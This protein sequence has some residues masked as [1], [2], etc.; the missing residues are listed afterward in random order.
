METQRKESL[1]D[2]VTRPDRDYEMMLVL[3]P[4]MPEE[5]TQA[6]IDKIRGYITDVNA[7]IT[8][9]LTDSP[10]GR[11][12]LAYTIRYESVDYRDG[13]YVVI[14]FT[15]QPS[16]IGEIERELKLDTN[17]IRY[18]I[19]MD[20]PKAG[21]K[22]T[23]QPEAVT[24]EA[25]EETD[26]APAEAATAEEAPADEPTAAEEANEAPAAESSES[27]EEAAVDTEPEVVAADESDDA[28]S[29]TAEA[30]EGEEEP[31]PA[32]GVEAEVATKES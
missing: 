13:F 6:A 9:T 26:A 3:I 23:E 18:M 24:A 4:D 30:I 16:V 29:Q 27:V 10:W 12:R 5:D 21:E 14:H 32:D 17:V 25:S 22:V 8:A 1:L 7:E 15:S 2:K 20:D 11:R 19:V 31:A 28:V